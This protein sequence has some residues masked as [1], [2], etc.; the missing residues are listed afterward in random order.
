VQYNEL[1]KYDTAPIKAYR[2][3]KASLYC[4]VPARS[5][6]VLK[7]AHLPQPLARLTPSFTAPSTSIPTPTLRARSFSGCATSAAFGSCFSGSWLLRLRAKRD[8]HLSAVCD[9]TVYLNSQKPRGHN[10]IPYPY[11]Q[12][13]PHRLCGGA[14]PCVVSLSPLVF[15]GRGWPSGAR[16]FFLSFFLR[17]VAKTT[18]F[19]LYTSR[20]PS[21]DA[22]V[23]AQR[24]Q[25]PHP[26]APKGDKH[27]VRGAIRPGREP[28]LP[29][30]S[31]S[32]VSRHRTRSACKELIPLLERQTGC[33]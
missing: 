25:V 15:H 12:L 22:Q 1:K 19:E 2:T 20:A 29:N 10:D 9:G 28:H 14:Q 6:L 31:S 32:S 7:C 24:E 4:T 27:R 30:C 5:F 26:T 17:L 8:P 33:V 3:S 11:P 21:R 13:V 23:L 16:S 18:N